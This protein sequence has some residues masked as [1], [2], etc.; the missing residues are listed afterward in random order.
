MSIFGVAL[1]RLNIYFLSQAIH[2]RCKRRANHVAGPVLLMF[3]LSLSACGGSNSTT[4]TIGYAIGDA[5]IAGGIVFYITDGGLHGLEAA[6]VDQSTSAV[7]GCLGTDLTGADG[8]AVGT[9]AQNT[10]DILAGCMETP[11]A[12]DLAAGYTL[13]GYSDWFLPSFDELGELYLQRDVV[14]GFSI[15]GYW[16]SSEAN[17]SFAWAQILDDGN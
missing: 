6:P 16:S 11:I 7:W 13:N 1:G 9:G 17:A 5:G 14:G 2:S 12:A 15:G 4:T 8:S 10:A 3:A